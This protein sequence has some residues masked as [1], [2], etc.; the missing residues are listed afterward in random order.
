MLHRI[1]FSL[2]E[3]RG[4]LYIALHSAQS[5]ESIYNIKLLLVY[6]FKWKS[7]IQVIEIS[8]FDLRLFTAE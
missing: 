8:T 3:I 4:D 6:S 1:V 2:V 7:F 5:D